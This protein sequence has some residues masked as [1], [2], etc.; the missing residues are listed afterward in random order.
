MT[1]ENGDS[2][3]LMSQLKDIMTCGMRKSQIGMLTNYHV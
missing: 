1:Q 2:S 3:S